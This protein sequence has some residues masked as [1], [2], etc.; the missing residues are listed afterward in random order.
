MVAHIIETS[1]L[2]LDAIMKILAQHYAAVIHQPVN[3]SPNQSPNQSV[4]QSIHQSLMD[5]HAADAPPFCL[6]L[7]IFP[8]LFLMLVLLCRLKDAVEWLSQAVL[9]A[10]R[11]QWKHFGFVQSVRLAWSQPIIKPCMLNVSPVLHP[12]HS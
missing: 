10:A 11:L 4:N 9:Q 1:S 2:A 7:C 6:L 12:L 3:Q 5:G 8:L